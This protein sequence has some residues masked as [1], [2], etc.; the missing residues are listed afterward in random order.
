MS[1][2]LSRVQLYIQL[3]EA[4]KTS[5]SHPAKSSDDRV[6]LKLTREAPDHAPDRYQGQP[7][8]KKQA[9]LILSPSPI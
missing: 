1:E 6:K 7:P 2:V 3:E 9:L 4:I 8:Y 5:S